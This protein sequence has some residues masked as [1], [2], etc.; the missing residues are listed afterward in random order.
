MMVKI[1]ENGVC[2]HMLDC[3]ITNMDKIPAEIKLRYRIVEM[4][5]QRIPR[6]VDDRLAG[7]YKPCHLCFGEINGES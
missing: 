6:Y 3:P 1:A 7:Y 5:G 4:N 2:Y